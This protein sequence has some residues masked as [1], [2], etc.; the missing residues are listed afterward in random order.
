MDAK[1]SDCL[2][3]ELHGHGWQLCVNATTT[4][5]HG[6]GYSVFEK[7]NSHFLIAVFF[8][9]CHYDTYDTEE[10]KE[11]REDEPS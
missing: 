7:K 1:Y 3:T 2:P 11:K 8:K 5:V 6:D 10:K 4:T 9:R